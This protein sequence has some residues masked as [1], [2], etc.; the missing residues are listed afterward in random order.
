MEEVLN[1]PLEVAWSHPTGKRS[2]GGPRTQWRNDIPHLARERL[3]THQEE[4][5]SV[6]REDI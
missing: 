2:Q 4:L 3:R 6:A 1:K 5:E